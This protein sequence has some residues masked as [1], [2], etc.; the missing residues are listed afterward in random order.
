MKAEL[1][2]FEKFL[3]GKKT[4]LISAGGIV[5][6]VVRA[7]QAHH[8]QNMATWIFAG[9]G[10]ASF[11]AAWAELTVLIGKILSK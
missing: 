8:W 7:I 3:I 1:N 10:L 2:T 9:G 4:Y 11:R 5:W 6:G